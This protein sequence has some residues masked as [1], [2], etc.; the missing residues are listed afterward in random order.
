MIDPDDIVTRLRN[1]PWTTADDCK[2]AADEIER[3]RAERNQ[4]RAEVVDRALGLRHPISWS[5]ESLNR[6]RCEKYAA[7]RGWHDLWDTVNE[8]ERLL[9]G[10]AS[11]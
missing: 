11:R 7:L 8:K 10:E 6:K 1:A 2:E 4:L 5:P 9:R 3:L